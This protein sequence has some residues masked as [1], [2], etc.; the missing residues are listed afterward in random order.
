MKLGKFRE[1]WKKFPFFWINSRNFQKN[2]KNFRKNSRFCHL[3]L[4]FTAEK[5]QKKPVYVFFPCE[6]VKLLTYIFNV[7]IKIILRVYLGY[8]RHSQGEVEKGRGGV[9]DWSKA[10]GGRQN[11]SWDP[12]WNEYRR[13]SKWKGSA[14]SIRHRWNAHLGSR[15]KP[16]SALN[17]S[18]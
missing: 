15:K 16:H 5:R 17:F 12:A 2:S 7:Y 11:T 9:R 1:F 8:F 14:T 3:D 13:S 6:C 4:V 10:Q 18:K